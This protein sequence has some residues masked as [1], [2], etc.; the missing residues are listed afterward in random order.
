MCRECDRILDL[1][2]ELRRGACL[3]CIPDHP[4][5]YEPLTPEEQAEADE[6]AICHVDASR[7]I[8][9]R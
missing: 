8:H 6:C 9:A 7:C 5:L 2:S 4:K 3:N 1:R